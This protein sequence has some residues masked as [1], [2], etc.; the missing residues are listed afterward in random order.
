MGAFVMLS[1]EKVRVCDTSVF[2]P[3]KS[4]FET[5]EKDFL[6]RTCGLVRG[7]KE[8]WGMWTVG[9]EGAVFGRAASASAEVEAWGGASGRAGSGSAAGA[10]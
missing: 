7:R 4:Q 8:R 6:A 10:C 5:R 9:R 3:G 1:P 2:E